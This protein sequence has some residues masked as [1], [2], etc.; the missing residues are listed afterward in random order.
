MAETKGISDGVSVLLWAIDEA[1][2]RCQYNGNSFYPR[3]GGLQ[4][5]TQLLTMND[6]EVRMLHRGI[7]NKT[8]EVIKIIRRLVME[9][10]A[11]DAEQKLRAKGQWKE[12]S[13]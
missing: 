12:S 2:R 10:V 4:G 1:Q 6:K 5:L 7:G 11:Q 9:A 13:G 3:V 8:C